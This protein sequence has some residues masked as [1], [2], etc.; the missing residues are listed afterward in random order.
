[1][2]VCVLSAAYPTG[3][4]ADS[5]CFIKDQA[6]LIKEMNCE[7]SVVAPRIFPEDDLFFWDDAIKVY[8]FPFLS[9]ERFLAEYERIPVAR[10]LSYLLSGTLKTWQAVRKERAEIIHA[11][12]VIP[13]GLIAVIVGKYLSNKPVVVT[14]HRADITVF[15]QKSWFA[16]LAAGFVLNRADRVVAVSNLL[17]ERIGSEY[18]VEEAKIEVVNMG[19]N[20]GLFKRRDKSAVRRKLGLPAQKKIVLFAGGLIRVKG[21]EYL[22]GA[23]SLLA[24]ELNE[25]LFVIVGTGSLERDLKSMAE[26]LGVSEFVR[27]V[28]ERPHGEIPLWVS[29]A[30]VVA[31]PSL[32]EGL[33]V[34]LMEALAAGVPVIATRVGGVPEV[35]SEGVNGFLIKPGDCEALAER[36]R[37]LIREERIYRLMSADCKL[38]ENCD[39]ERNTKRVVQVY[40]KV[41][42]KSGPRYD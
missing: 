2:R 35:V 12:W 7:V 16:R 25:V 29:C 36:V 40:E 5:G 23:A 30:D 3:R 32:D 26:R 37:L 11:H 20:S 39:M 13:T 38:P 1:M 18:G 22:L 10:V 33:P 28:G 42:A 34:V 31:I 17:K 9:E 21:V 27:F 8:R 15:P 24:G 41:L 19:V 4:R 14:A 6:L